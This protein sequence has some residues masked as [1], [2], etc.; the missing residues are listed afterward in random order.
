VRNANGSIMVDNNG[1]GMMDYG[2]GITARL[3]CP[4]IADAIP[5]LDK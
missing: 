5:I 3:Q 4:F 2:S 1:L